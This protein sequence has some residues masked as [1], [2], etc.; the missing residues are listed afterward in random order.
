MRVRILKL[1]LRGID[2]LMKFRLDNPKYFNLNNLFEIS[3]NGALNRGV[4]KILIYSKWPWNPNF[5]PGPAIWAAK[6]PRKLVPAR[7]LGFMAIWNK[8]ISWTAP[9]WGHHLGIFQINGWNW[10]IVDY[11]KRTSWRHQFLSNCTFQFESII[12]L[13]QLPLLGIT[14]WE[15]LMF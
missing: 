5:S 9:C 3:L 11:P 2:V 10:N 4:F 12:A 6:R 7:S 15:E 1:H 13:W 14:F 8:W